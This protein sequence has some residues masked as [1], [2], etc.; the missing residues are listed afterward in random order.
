MPCSRRS[1]GT[2]NAEP[3]AQQRSLPPTWGRIGGGVDERL[4]QGEGSMNALSWI[5]IRVAPLALV[6]FALLAPPAAAEVRCATFTSPALGRAV[7]YALDLPSSY[8]GGDRRY[9]VVY[10]LH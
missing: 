9:P 3:C 8:A 1:R 2:W 7:S 6:L 4:G 5:C 10:A